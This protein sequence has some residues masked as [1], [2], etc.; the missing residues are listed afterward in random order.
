MFFTDALCIEAGLG[1]DASTCFLVLL[2][3]CI[4]F[5]L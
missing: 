5:W 1:E 3:E 2:V 4:S